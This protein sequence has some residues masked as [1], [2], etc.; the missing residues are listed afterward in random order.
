MQAVILHQKRLQIVY[1]YNVG[2]ANH[3]TVY[4]IRVFV[5]SPHTR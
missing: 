3:H 4:K 1:L 2:K 5:R